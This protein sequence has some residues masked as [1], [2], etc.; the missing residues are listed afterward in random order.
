[1]N[2]QLV[3][4]PALAGLWLV[5][6]A[7]L[8]FRWP[9]LAWPAARPLG[10]VV[11]AVLLI[12]ELAAIGVCINGRAAGVIIDARNCM[13]LSK[14]QA[15]GWTVVV[16]AAVLVAAAFNLSLGRPD[17]LNIT[18]PNDLLVAMG[19]SAASMAAT[20]AVLSLKANQI[21]SDVA[22]QAAANQLASPGVPM[23]AADVP[24][25]GKMITNNSSAEAHWTDMLTGDEIGNFATPDLS[26][27]QQLLVTLLLLGVYSVLVWR[28]FAVPGPLKALP[29]IDQSFIWLLGI[30]QASYIAYKAAPHTT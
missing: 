20:P 10:F 17:A 12:L 1:M 15:C 3:F 8:A 19:I 27:I 4:G 2:R 26:K 6:L 7:V 14:L 30:S 5:L 28:A 18:I 13:S 9:L 16:L 25:I 24:R 22:V 29:P 23:M 11:A 21:P